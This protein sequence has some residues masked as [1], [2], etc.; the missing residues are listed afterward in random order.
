MKRTG[1]LDRFYDEWEATV[2]RERELCAY[3]KSPTP[4]PL[5]HSIHR[6]GFGI[7]PEVPLCNE[8]GGG[9][10]PTCE[11]IWKRIALGP[12]SWWKGGK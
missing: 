3:C 7:G 1:N 2:E 8:C 5:K 6:D 12:H 9:S 4:K 10:I 11:E